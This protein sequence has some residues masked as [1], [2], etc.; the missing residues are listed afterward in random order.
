MHTH[1]RPWSTSSRPSLCALVLVDCIAAMTFILRRWPPALASCRY[2]SDGIVIPFEHSVLADL[3]DRAAVWES[4]ALRLCMPCQWAEMQ[5]AVRP[6]TYA[7]LH[8]GRHN[9]PIG[10]KSITANCELPQHVDPGD[11]C[12]FLGWYFDGQSNPSAAASVCALPLH[13]FQR[14]VHLSAGH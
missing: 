2:K 9:T 1:L 14:Q 8:H 3:I 12:S 4:E 5:E 11:V 13:S 10:L 7:T 6:G